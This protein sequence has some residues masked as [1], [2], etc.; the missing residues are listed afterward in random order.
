MSDATL[1]LRSGAFFHTFVNQ[2]PVQDKI[3]KK[4]VMDAYYR[5][6]PPGTYPCVLLYIDIDPKHVDVNVHPRKLEVKFVDSGS[7]YARV[8]ELVSNALGQ[9]KIQHG[10]RKQQ[11]NAHAYTHAQI[12]SSPQESSKTDE[13]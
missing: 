3:I 9:Q 11:P 12:S 8:H 5:Q 6:L 4:A 13:S 10:T 2:R 7:I 1:P